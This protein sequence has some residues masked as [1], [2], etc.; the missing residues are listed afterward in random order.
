M[1]TVEKYNETHPHCNLRHDMHLLTELGVYKLI[2]RSN[3]P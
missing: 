2:L 3:K 1:I